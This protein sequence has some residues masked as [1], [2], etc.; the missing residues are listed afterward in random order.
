MA[1]NKVVTNTKTAFDADTNPDYT[2]ATDEIAGV[3]YQFVKLADPTL[4]S[5]SGI[6]VAGNPMHVQGTVTASGGATAARQDTGNTSLATVAG[7]V[8]G[9]EMQV[10]VLTM[11]VVAVS[12]SGVWDEVGINDSGNSITVDN[13]TLSV[14]GGGVEATALRVTIASDSTGI[15]SVDDNGGS[16]TVDGTV[17]ISGAIDTEL[18]AAGALADNTANPTT[19]SVG[20]FPHW[21]DGATWDR[22]LGNATDGCLVNLGANN[23]VTV[24]GTVA[25]T[26]SGTWDEVGINDSGNSITVDNG[27]TFVVQEN[28]AA[29]TALQLIDDTV[30]TLGTTTYTETTTKGLTIGAVRRDADTTL[31]GTTNEIGPL[32]MDANGYL[33]VEIFDG[34]GSHTVDNA[35][36]FVVQENGAA[37]TALQLIDN[38]ISGAGFNITQ[39]NGVNITMGNG[40]SGTG[41][42]RVTIASDSTGTIAVTS[43]APTNDTSAAYEASSVTKASA[44]TLWGF[45]GYNSKTADQFI[46]F[47]NSTTVPADATAAVLVWKVAALS[48]F[49]LDFG[50]KGRSFSTGIAWSN[51]STAPTKTI[52]S[53]DIFLDAQYT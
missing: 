45:S 3:D 10:D 34:G 50:L 24:T 51:S 37:L 46:L 1:D 28:G 31:V 22:A 15:L 13:A 40:V 35:G 42:Q 41:V 32:Q 9:T 25:V 23:D 20:T 16:L 30:A 52:G 5:T 8:S 2:A 47:F 6:G 7:A 26:Q 49:S 27:G 43:V 14:V 29:L 44:G 53:A 11:P 33:K 12:Q 48:P 36:T 21:Y 38:A 17:A 39:L 4:G 19:T 18:P